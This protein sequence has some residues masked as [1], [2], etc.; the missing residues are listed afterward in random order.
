MAASGT[1]SL[2][3]IDSVTANAEGGRMNSEAYRFLFFA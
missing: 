1:E 2:V 3:F